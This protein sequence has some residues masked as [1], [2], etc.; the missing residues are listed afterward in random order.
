MTDPMTDRK[1]QREHLGKIADKIAKCQHQFVPI[2]VGKFC[3][4]C[5]LRVVNMRTKAERDLVMHEQIKGGLPPDKVSYDEV[6]MTQY[7]FGTEKPK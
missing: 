2:K 4:E 6:M 3:S 1:W 7:D 5:G